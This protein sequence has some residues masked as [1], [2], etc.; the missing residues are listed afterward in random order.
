M[1]HPVP[2]G[3]LWSWLTGR[4]PSPAPEPALIPPP[5]PPPQP[6]ETVQFSDP[7]VEQMCRSLRIQDQRAAGLQVAQ[8][9]LGLAGIALELVKTG[10]NDSEKARIAQGSLEY[11]RDQKVP[12][13]WELGLSLT[14]EVRYDAQRVAVAQTVL[15]ARASEPIAGLGLAAARSLDSSYSAPEVLKIQH[16]TLQAL[17]TPSSRQALLLASKVRY[18][19]QKQILYQTFLEKP[20]ARS[21]VELKELSLQAAGRL[22]S[23]YSAPDI[24]KIQRTLIDQLADDPAMGNAMRLSRDLA[25]KVRY[26]AQKTEFYKIALRDCQTPDQPQAV[27]R[28]GLAM[29]GAMD[30]SYS[31]PDRL[32]GSLL[33]MNRLEGYPETANLAGLARLMV[34]QVRYDTQKQSL[35]DAVFQAVLNGQG[36]SLKVADQALASLDM[37]YSAPD[38]LKV[39]VAVLEQS[40]NAD[41]NL[42]LEAMKSVRYDTQRLGMAK[43]IF[44]HL[45]AP[46]P[47][48][49]SRLGDELLGS[50]DMSYSGPDVL[51]AGQVLG[52]RYS[53]PKARALLDGA[54]SGQAMKEAFQAIAHIDDDISELKNMARAVK[55]EGPPA[56]IV[57]KQGA[58]LVGGVRLRV[59]KDDCETMPREPAA[60]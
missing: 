13:P 53:N 57:E 42:V 44:R 16:R 17:E 60:S 50:F 33:L 52:R 8:S 47:A 12:G 59:R 20:E 56:A 19:A 31:A 24:Q 15:A 55:G 32:Q 46:E 54:T 26:D 6:V 5:P 43:V 2:A 27:L 1:L 3:G 49:F 45:L 34:G 18:D 22:D 9:Q 14:R 41:A 36:D 38:F 21:P 25:G 48:P 7:Q 23:S 39:A 30:S 37:S 40:D 35:L 29:L 4:K 28:Q 58:V 51:K 10:R 11:L